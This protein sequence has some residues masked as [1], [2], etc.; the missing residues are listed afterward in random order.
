MGCVRTVCKV[1]GPRWEVGSEQPGRGKWEGRVGRWEVNSRERGKWEGR[2]GRW[3]VNSREK[4]ESR[5][6]NWRK[7]TA[8]NSY[9]T[10]FFEAAKLIFVK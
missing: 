5:K 1:G 3:E 10:I 7:I 9:F 2:V 8:V 4:W 6:Y